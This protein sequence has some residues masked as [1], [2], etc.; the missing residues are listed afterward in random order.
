MSNILI[1][2][3]SPCYPCEY[4]IYEIDEYGECIKDECNR[5]QNG[6]C[7]IEEWCLEQEERKN[8]YE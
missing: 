2:Y 8:N 5:P 6:I 7:W 4:N 1:P 3:V